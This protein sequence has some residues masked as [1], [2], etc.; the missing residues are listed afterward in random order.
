MLYISGLQLQTYT[1]NEFLSRATAIVVIGPRQN[2]ETKPTSL[3]SPGGDVW[4]VGARKVR[5]TEEKKIGVKLQLTAEWLIYNVAKTRLKGVLLEL[6]SYTCMKS[7]F[8]CEF[9]RQVNK[10]E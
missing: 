5:L 1:E 7:L 2:W 8:K 9:C 3:F 10:S 4:N 6:H